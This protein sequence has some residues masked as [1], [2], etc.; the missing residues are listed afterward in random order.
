[1]HSARGAKRPSGHGNSCGKRV[2]A[3]SERWREHRIKVRAEFVDAAFRALDEQGPDVSMGDIARH[4]GAAKP[5]LYR[6]FEDKTD[7]YNAVVERL[8]DLLWERILAD[9]DL[10]HDPAREVVRRSIAEYARVVSEH[11]NVFRF[12]VHSH[13]TQQATDSERAL[14]SLRQSAKRAA[15]MLVEVMDPQ[16]VD[17]DGAEMVI[18]SIFGA[19]GSSTDWWLGASRPMEQATFANYLTASV[20]GIA[21]SAATLSG[22]RF[23]PEVPLPQAFSTQPAH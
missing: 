7:L 15:T 21:S 20:F 4:A 18:Y 2:D 8:Q 6:H 11:P 9:T 1:M 13:F 22:V 5:K 16:S 23:D 10:L 14:Q 19:V 3:R 12:M 17:V